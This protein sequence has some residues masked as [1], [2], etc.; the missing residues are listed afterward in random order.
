[1]ELSSPSAADEVRTACRALAHTTEAESPEVAAAGLDLATA[2][3]G[4]S[5]SAAPSLRLHLSLQTLMART[6]AAA[7]SSQAGRIWAA[8]QNLAELLLV[9]GKFL[10]D[11]PEPSW[12]EEFPPALCGL[13]A[14]RREFGNFASVLGWP[15]PSDQFGLDEVAQALH[16]AGQLIDP[17]PE[18]PLCQ[19]LA[20]ASRDLVRET[21]IAWIESHLSDGQ[22]PSPAEVYAWYWNETLGGAALDGAKVEEAAAMASGLAK[23]M[24]LDEVV[25]YLRDP[26]QVAYYGMMNVLPATPTRWS[27]EDVDAADR[28]L[29]YGL[30]RWYRRPLEASLVP[31]DVIT[32]V[33]RTRRSYYY[34]RMF[35]HALV[36]TICVQRVLPPG[37]VADA[38]V[39]KL[40]A[41]CDLMLDGYRLR[42]QYLARLK[43]TQGWVEYLN[44]LV[45]LHFPDGQAAPCALSG[46]EQTIYAALAKVLYGRPN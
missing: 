15:P 29:H 36:Q 45:A 14:V 44:A 33:L 10:D 3:E 37:I 16:S 23:W 30:A 12:A 24:G 35:A 38:I 20:G 1:M 42:C 28:Q 5:D 40:A 13:E 46:G 27:L 22:D 2:A 34:N 25:D 9:T 11:A 26:D 19:Y 4:V 18:A 43:S 6:Q 39:G 32:G 17:A 7:T 41:F 8:A 31:I 21:H